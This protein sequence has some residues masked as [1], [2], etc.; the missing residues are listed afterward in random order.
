M[1][2]FNRRNR[3]FISPAIQGRLVARF[4]FYWFA[5]H[6]VLWHTMFAYHFLKVTVGL[7]SQ[8]HGTLFDLYSHFAVEHKSFLLCGLSVAPLILWDALLVSHRIVG[9][10]VRVQNVLKRLSRGEKVPEVTLRDGDLLTDLRDALNEYLAVSG[11]L[12]SASPPVDPAQ[13]P[14]LK[15]QDEALLAEVQQLVELNQSL[16]TD[17]DL[18]ARHLHRHS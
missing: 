14:A 17:S 7:S 9:P 10:I 3:V 18:A 5:Y 11:N 15:A 1:G 12:I 6:L 8:P 13:Q 4:C 2:A 16:Q